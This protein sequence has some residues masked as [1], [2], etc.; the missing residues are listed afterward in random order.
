MVGSVCLS[1][2]ELVCV[3]MQAIEMVRGSALMERDNDIVQGEND[4]GVSF[5]VD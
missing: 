2:R 4:L 1:S 5:I 3:L